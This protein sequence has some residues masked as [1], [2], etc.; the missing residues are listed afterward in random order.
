MDLGGRRRSVNEGRASCSFLQTWQACSSVTTT[1]ADRLSHS[2][3]AYL[4]HLITGERNFGSSSH[5]IKEE[6]SRSR[7]TF[8]VLK[9]FKVKKE[10]VSGSWKVVKVL[11]QERRL[12]RRW[13]SQWCRCTGA[14][15]NC[16]RK[17]CFLKK[18]DT[19]EGRKKRARKVA[20]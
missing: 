2:L 14:R 9:K 5:P 7:P 11:L 15:L 1:E 12:V 3:C 18:R 20:V 19:F 16:E 8:C 13:C 4:I 10:S 6:C 17:V